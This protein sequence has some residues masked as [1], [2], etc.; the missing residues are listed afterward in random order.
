[1]IK[2]SDVVKISPRGTITIPSKYR[3]SL[4]IKNNSF[5][6]IKAT[7]EGVLLRPVEIKEKSGYTKKELKK[8]EQLSDDKKNSGKIFN[9]AQ[10]ATKHLRS[11]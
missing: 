7:K 10:E 6:G 1:M 2:I 4:N 3:K 11:L 8:I 5:I 9:S